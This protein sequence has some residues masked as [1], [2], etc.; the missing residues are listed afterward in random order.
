MAS[1]D[2]FIRHTYLSALCK[3]LASIA[4]FGKRPSGD[5]VPGII[6]GEGFARR[7]AISGIAER[8]FFS[9]VVPEPRRERGKGT[10]QPLVR[11]SGLVTEGQE[12]ALKQG[13][14]AAA[15]VLE[16]LAHHL[17]ALNIEWVESD[18]LKELYQGLVDPSDR[19]DLGEYYTPRTAPSGPR[20]RPRR[21]WW[22]R[23]PG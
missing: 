13:Q 3:L 10:D 23:S 1:E 15:E 7:G 18:M 20:L 17:R 21:S 6:T 11:F 8:D 9:W 19:H 14:D 4:L 12:G 5:E 16:G 22:R 2:L